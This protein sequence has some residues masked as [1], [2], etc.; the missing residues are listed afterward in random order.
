MKEAG[1]EHVPEGR[2]D[3]VGWGG[4]K[5]IA[6]RRNCASECTEGGPCTRAKAHQLQ[7]GQLGLSRGFRGL[8]DIFRM[9]G[10][11]ID[12]EGL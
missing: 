11:G 8:L 12:L 1:H 2:E 3:S 6:G 10:E 9:S 7:V 5:G 4:G